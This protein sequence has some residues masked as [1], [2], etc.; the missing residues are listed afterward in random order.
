M[1]RDRTTRRTTS[2]AFVVPWLVSCLG[3]VL[4]LG[5][6][7]GLCHGTAVAQTE[8]PSDP[9]P[10]Y[11]PP[12]EDR[13]PTLQRGV[14]ED[15]LRGVE[16]LAYRCTNSLGLRDVTLFGNGTVR[17]LRRQRPSP[18]LT[19]ADLGQVGAVGRSLDPDRAVDPR[20]ELLLDELTPQ[21]LGEYLERLEAV[22]RTVE[23]PTEPT[24]A[25]MPE[26]PWVERCTMRLKLADVPPLRF[27]WGAYE[28][29]PLGLARLV[30]IA[31]ELAAFTRE[32]ALPERLPAHYVA[33]PG[34]VLRRPD[35]SR[36]RVVRRTDDGGGIELENLD[37]PTRVFYRLE[38]LR[39]VFVA[40][41]FRQPDLFG[42]D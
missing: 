2:R 33:R 18:G 34:D 1:A 25:R 31:D 6:S 24:R 26:G 4:A 21:L 42:V 22:R 3:L 9:I 29:P 38:D 10:L 12:I 8:P 39:Q 30:E 16:R 14:G 40:V 19:G 28:V 35:G 27:D 13:A 32:P 20:S 23:L 36:A 7:L 15:D 41:E 17:L 5:S 11:E 37:Q